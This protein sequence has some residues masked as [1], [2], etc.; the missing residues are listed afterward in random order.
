MKLDDGKHVKTN[1]GKTEML[2]VG[3][4]EELTDCLSYMGNNIEIV[5]EEIEH[6]SSVRN[7]GFH[8]DFRSSVHIDYL[9]RTSSITMKCISK[10]RHL[11]DKDMTKIFFSIWMYLKLIL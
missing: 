8:M 10:I 7:V 11:L 6:S 4:K 2:F 5:G 1:W 3:T 9:S